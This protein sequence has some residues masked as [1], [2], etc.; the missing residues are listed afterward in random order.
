MNVCFWRR[1]TVMM[2]VSLGI[3]LWGTGGCESQKKTTDNVPQKS[4]G[5]SKLG[6]VVVGDVQSSTESPA[7]VAVLGQ[8]SR[9]LKKGDSVRIGEIIRCGAGTEAE[10][11]FDSGT[12]VLM[13]ENSSFQLGG[14]PTIKTLLG[15]LAIARQVGAPTPFVLELDQI[16]Y[17]VI[18]GRV[19]VSASN[20]AT[21]MDIQSGEVLRLDIN[22]YLSTGEQLTFTKNAT[23]DPSGSKLAKRPWPHALP[24]DWTP[25]I[26]PLEPASLV[27]VPSSI[28]RGIGTLFARNPRTQKTAQNAMKMNAHLVDVEIHEGVAITKVEERFTNTSNV[29]V[30][31]TYRFLVPKEAEITRLALD[32]NGRIEEGEVL[33]KKRAARIFKQ[34]VDDSVRPRDPALLEWE[35]GSAFKMKIFPIKPK[36]TRRVFLTYVTPMVAMSG[37]Y[38]YEYPLANPAGSVPVDEFSIH[39]TVQ[40]RNALRNVRTPMFESN[41]NV[42]THSAQIGWTTRQQAP[43]RDFVITFETESN[44]AKLRSLVQT[45]KNG[46]SYGMFLWQPDARHMALN[47]DTPNEVSPPVTQPRTVVAMV[48]VSFGVQREMIELAAA[49]LVELIGGLGHSD[50]FTVLACDASCRPLF[51]GFKAPDAAAIV[52]MY[53]QLT[54]IE[55]GGASNLLGNFQLAFGKLRQMQRQEQPIDAL[56]GDVVYLGDGI[57][58][59]GELD[60]ATLINKLVATKPNGVRVHTVGIGPAVDRPVLTRMAAQMDGMNYNMSVGESPGSA[61]WHLARM[62]TRDALL[63]VRATLTVDNGQS[64]P[65]HGARIG[66]LPAGQELQ[67]LARLDHLSPQRPQAGTLV[68]SAQTMAGEPIEKKY[69]VTLAQSPPATG[70]VSRLWAAKEI[71]RLEFEQGSDAQIVELSRKH[72]IASRLTSWIVL[73]NQRMYDAFN[74]Q[75]TDGEDLELTGTPF[76]EAEAA[77]E[78]DADAADPSGKG[79]LAEEE[80]NGLGSGGGGRGKSASTA[81]HSAPKKRSAPSK[82]SPLDDLLSSGSGSGRTEKKKE[83]SSSTRRPPSRAPRCDGPRYN[84]VI[85]KFTGDGANARVKK[86]QLQS[87]LGAQLLSRSL[88]RRYVRHLAKMTNRTEALRAAGEWQNADAFSAAAVRAYGA[89][90]ARSGNRAHAAR[91]YSAI[92]E[93]FPTQA[94]FHQRLAPMFRDLGDYSAA[95]GH[96]GALWSLENK[97]L[98]AALG[99]THTLRDYLF[100][101]VMSGQHTLYRFEVDNTQN[102]RAIAALGNI[103]NSLNEAVAT[104]VIP[105]WPL[106]TTKGPL[107]ITL[108]NAT[109]DLDILLVDPFGRVSGGLWRFGADVKDWT[110]TTGETLWS[111]APF[112]GRYQ[113]VITRANAKSIA[114]AKGTVTIQL[115]GK[116][117]AIP[118]EFAEPS[119]TIATINYTQLPNKRCFAW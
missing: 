17:S 22:T 73:E 101:L 38:R 106:H 92:S 32:V 99:N 15:N 111:S 84:V 53:R 42:D 108:Q 107:R 71:E 102:A 68:I 62:F 51:N 104:G 34:I 52:Q 81:S 54:A 110:S 44:S 11:R 119:A 41:L 77:D 90:V 98:A 29:T 59:S 49:T 103:V 25:S 40:T 72:R 94:S 30:E 95:A 3:L 33:E 85:A 48:D 66:F 8:Q 58:T 37:Y 39:A 14:H 117:Q 50:R 64:V 97:N 18:Q 118:F 79:G 55:P 115:K 2:A 57:A 27:K 114:Q 46:Q 47:G 63:N 70:F 105:D 74:V 45:E 88:H 96:Y 82:S 24:A 61:A 56:A 116:R 113:V 76:E 109:E 19:L 1:Q 91:M 87:E 112:T 5:K 93:V 23:D 9:L 31:A 16:Q 26:S 67:M 12:R 78:G 100:A 21:R 60:A 6:L 75:R 43:A 35:R 36:E 4:I 10:I 7:L 69:N 80:L 86:T 28:P 89:E 83:A 13:M 65:L 20:A